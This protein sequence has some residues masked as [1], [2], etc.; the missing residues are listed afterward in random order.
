M[1]LGLGSGSLASYALAVLVLFAA[2]C[3]VS[4]V[5]EPGR[6][7]KPKNEPDKSPKSSDS[8]ARIPDAFSPRLDENDDK[9]SVVGEAVMLPTI[10]TKKAEPATT[11]ANPSTTWLN[12]PLSFLMLKKNLMTR[13]EPPKVDLKKTDA[14]TPKPSLPDPLNDLKLPDL[15]PVALELTLTVVTPS[16]K[17]GEDAFF[18]LSGPDDLLRDARGEYV[19]SDALGRHLARGVIDLSSQVGKVL[20]REFR[21]SPPADLVLP[22]EMYKGGAN[23]VRLHADFS[24]VSPGKKASKLGG[25]FAL[26]IPAE[27]KPLVWDRWIAMT[28]NP[29]VSGAW[30]KLNEVGIFGGMQ[31]RT[32]A[33]RRESLRKG[34]APFY[35]ENVTRQMLSRYHTEKGLWQKTITAIQA[36]RNGSAPLSREPSLC[37]QAFADA[38]GGEIQRISEVY[39]TD[40]PLFFSLSSEPSMTRLNAA[41]DFDFS[42]AALDEFRRWLERDAYGTIQ[43]LNESWGT[44]F[45]SWQTVVPMTTDDVRLRLK[46]GVGNF[47]PWADFREFQDYTFSKVLREG[48]DLLRTRIPR[49]KVGVTGAMG[50]FA[51]GGWDWSRLA[52]DLDVVEAYDIGGARALWRDL[53]PGKAALAALTLPADG[54]AATVADVSR[55]A[56]QFALEGGP[57][58]VLFWD[59]SNAGPAGGNALFDVSGAPTELAVALA[60]TLASLNGPTGRVLARS[61]HMDDGVAMLYSPASIRVNWLFEADK[62]HGSEW[63]QTW[64]ADSSAERRES[65]QLRLRESWEKLLDDCGIA[66][67][68]TSTRDV[69]RGELLR[70]ENGIKTLIL[71]RV[72][73]LSDREI[74]AIK[75]FA[76][77]GGRVI[78]D[79]VCGRFD[80]H[81]RLRARPALDDLFGVN[82]STEPIFPRPMKALNRITPLPGD[83]GAMAKWD[84][85]FWANL[86]PVFSDEPKWQDPERSGKRNGAEY[87]LC[88]VFATR[89]K[90]IYLNLDLTDYLRWRLHPELPR[91]KTMRKA[92]ID[93]VFQETLDTG[94]I[95]WSKTKLPHGT[96]VIRLRTSNAAKPG[97][98][99]ALRRNPQARLHELGVEGDGNWAFEKVEPFELHFKEPVWIDGI[100]AH[101]IGDD[102]RLMQSSPIKKLVGNVDPVK[103][104]VVSLRTEIPAK[105]DVSA[106][107][108]VAKLQRF[109]VAISTPKEGP[110]AALYSLRVTGPDTI[111]RAHYGGMIASKDG[112]L[113]HIISFALNDP[114]GKWTISVRD[115]MGGAAGEIKINVKDSEK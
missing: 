11:P 110:V 1:S 8:S 75:L 104:V 36:D 115:A 54:S 2:S 61:R 102:A 16:V 95:D 76:A 100:V 23:S 3:S 5:E 7:P 89:N 67:R 81:A 92:L 63:L 19:I 71:P 17:L 9:D 59:V 94:L 106:I 38:F 20:E 57:R 18:N 90:S 93:L 79:A 34:N 25:D 98:V 53:A 99:L 14:M 108:D 86:P 40:A 64:G 32:S 29:P 52:N 58:G 60:P 111:D 13:I 49:A 39:A 62:L 51:F 26:E 22:N 4:A 65:P 70:P 73:A 27:A 114:S 24:I 55:T 46:D 42:P 33:A 109:E 78:A 88:P 31:I 101:G 72:I 50:P 107:G 69:E 105:L 35:V 82:T 28:S 10:P 21:I 96:Q 113:S 112:A 83:T 84:A 15:D 77:N 97:I 12:D 87:R 80:E 91:A 48:A 43:A 45:E 44:Q 66:W 30:T 74:E 6:E 85:E 37:S 56:W 47:A 68:Y 41:V 103:P